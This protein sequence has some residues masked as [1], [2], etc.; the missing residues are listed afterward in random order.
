LSYIIQAKGWRDE[1]RRGRVT[2]RRKWLP[3][4]NL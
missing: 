1:R 3:F 2:G 4:A